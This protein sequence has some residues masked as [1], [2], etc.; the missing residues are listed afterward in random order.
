MTNAELFEALVRETSRFIRTKRE[1]IFQVDLRLRP[2]GTKGPLASSLRL[3]REYY[4]L[5]GPAHPFERLALVRLRWIAGSARLGNE[6]EQLRDQFVY[7]SPRFDLDVLW[8][9]WNK[10]HEQKERPGQLNAKYSSGA[11]TDLEGTVLL[12]QTTHARRVPQLRTPRLSA[13]LEGLRRGGVLAPEDYADLVGAYR[14]LRRLI[15]ALRM[16]RG[17]AQDL[18]LPPLGSDELTHLAR[19]VGYET[20]GGRTPGDQLA[21]EFQQRTAA[22]RAFVRKHFGRLCPGEREAGEPVGAPQPERA[23]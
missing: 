19:R 20:R 22:V 7:D 9:L 1:G 21:E 3:F 6:V 15:N 5:S 16:L 13:A 10:R 14:F 4:G 12:L 2:Y 18:F 17:N 8:D 11:L 23:V